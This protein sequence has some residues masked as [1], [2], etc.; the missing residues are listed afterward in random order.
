MRRSRKKYERPR[1][2]WQQKR[3]EEEAKLKEKFGLRNK[4]EI[5]KAEGRIRRYR[6][7]CRSLLERE[8]I[9]DE[10][11]E[12]FGFIE[13]LKKKGLLGENA[14]L[15]DV[16]RLKTDDLLERRLQTLV[17]KKGLSNSIKQAR[18]LIVHGHIAVVGSRVT[19]PGYIV[20]K[21]EESG[22]DY[23]VNSPFRKEE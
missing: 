9:V 15:D 4:R 8:A 13:S 10:G 7:K 1:Y 2:P 14:V 23:Y 22:I 3:F 11:R 5:W 16:L 19:V 21:G 17:F 6:S 20:N 18:Q 12:E